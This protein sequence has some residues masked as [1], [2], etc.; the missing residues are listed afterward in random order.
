MKIDYG[1]MTKSFLL[2]ETK[3][4]VNIM[5]HVQAIKEM[6]SNMKPKSQTE[7]NRLDAAFQHLKEVRRQAR[8]LQERVYTLEEQVKVLEEG[9]ED[10]E[11]LPLKLDPEH[12]PLE[13]PHTRRVRQQRK[14]AGKGR[15]GY[16]YTKPPRGKKQ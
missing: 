7:H 16:K 10:D 1:K 4:S 8:R 14:R 12:D 2:G 13:D 6:L 3:V 9:K 11:V 15:S 5:T